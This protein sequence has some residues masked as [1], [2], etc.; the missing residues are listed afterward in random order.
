M[1]AAAST[2]APV[3]VLEIDK[4]ETQYEKWILEPTCEHSNDEHCVGE[5]FTLF[6]NIQI[7]VCNTFLLKPLC[8]RSLFW[9]TQYKNWALETTF[10]HLDE[11]HH[12]GEHS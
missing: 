11:K 12:I 2:M 9:E 7:V 6:V 3:K 4:G 8:E 5:H 1:N 10:E